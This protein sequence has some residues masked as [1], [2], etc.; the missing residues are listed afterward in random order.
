[1]TKARYF[2]S[3]LNAWIFGASVILLADEP[4][5]YHGVTFG[6][7]FMLV[8]WDTCDFLDKQP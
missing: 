6:L 2:R 7:F 4:T 1:M 3:L 5:P 8:I